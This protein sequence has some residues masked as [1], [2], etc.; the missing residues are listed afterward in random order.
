[1]IVVR[2]IIPSRSGWTPTCNLKQAQCEQWLRLNIGDRFIEWDW[3]FQYGY[4]LISDNRP[5]EAAFFKLRF[6]V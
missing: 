1:M 3:A 6:G 4:A 2:C 5:E